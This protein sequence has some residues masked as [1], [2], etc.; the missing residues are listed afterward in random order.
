VVFP[1]ALSPAIASI[2]G[3]DVLEPARSIRN[4][5]SGTTHTPF[6]ARPRKASQASIGRA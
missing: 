6:L 1:A 5:L 4:N 2:T 3:R